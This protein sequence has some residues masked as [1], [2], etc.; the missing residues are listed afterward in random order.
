MAKTVKFMQYYHPNCKFFQYKTS[1]YDSLLIRF[2]FGCYSVV[3]RSEGSN[4][5][6]NTSV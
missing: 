2:L 3:I 1:C 6:R 4:N 5:N